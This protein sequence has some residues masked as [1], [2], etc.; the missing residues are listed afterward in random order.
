M[1]LH[2]IYNCKK[3]QR[4]NFFRALV[5]SGAP[6]KIR[7]EDGCLK[8]DY[9]L[10]EGGDSV[11]HLYEEWTCPEAQKVHLT[12][13]HMADVKTL[14]ELYVLNTELIRLD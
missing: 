9:D 4:D 7:K 5:A 8:Y 14:K 6:E 13:P 1:K 2:V 11:L 10:S 12:Q 3:G